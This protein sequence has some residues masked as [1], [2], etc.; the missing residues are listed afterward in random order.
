MAPL[1]FAFLFSSE[2]SKSICEE[3]CSLSDVFRRVRELGSLPAH[4]RS[5]T[6]PTAINPSAEPIT[7][8]YWPSVAMAVK[9]IGAFG[10]VTPSTGDVLPLL[11][12][13]PPSQNSADNDDPGNGIV[14]ELAQNHRGR[15]FPS[16]KSSQGEVG[17]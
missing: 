10:D 14:Q 8:H 17:R 2:Y 11:Q 7:D 6:A 3:K 13:G 1:F 5:P 16:F 15:R 9:E 12:H 4:Q